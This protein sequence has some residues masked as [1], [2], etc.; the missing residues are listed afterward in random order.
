MSIF[1]IKTV[2]DN[3]INETGELVLKEDRIVSKYFLGIKVFETD[4][5]RNT[6]QSDLNV[7]TTDKTIG[8]IK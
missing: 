4:Y 7:D 6:T 3:E 2:V 8:F 5:K 1:K